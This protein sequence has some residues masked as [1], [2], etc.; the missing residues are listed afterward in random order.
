[1]ELEQKALKELLYLLADDNLIHAYRGSEWLGLAPHIEE[2]VAFSSINQ[3][4][5]GHAKMYY[6]LLE[7][8]GEGKMDDLSHLRKPGEF[9]NAVL[10]EMANGTGTYLHKP[11]YDWAFTVVRHL[12]YAVFNQIRLESL[13]RS[14]YEPLAQTA[15]KIL[16]EQYYHLLHWKTWFNQLMSSTKEARMRMEN[17]IRRVWNEFFGVI[18]LGPFGNDMAGCGLIDSEAKLEAAWLGE[19]AAIFRQVGFQQAGK[20]QMLH[21][22]GRSGEHTEDLKEALSILQEVYISDQQ[23]A[24]W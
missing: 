21:G 11:N 10:L 12:F 19:V 17:A 20:P 22:D 3:D 13:S 4:T 24:Y 9:R 23:A 16:T 18:T 8:L 6:Q 5:M 7:E 15:G 2:D 14:S 1:M